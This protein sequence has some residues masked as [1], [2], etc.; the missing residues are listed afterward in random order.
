MK[1]YD[2]YIILELILITSNVNLLMKNI[3]F[4]K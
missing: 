4:E 1:Y 2:E 3:K